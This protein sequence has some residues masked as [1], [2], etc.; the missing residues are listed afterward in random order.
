MTHRGSKRWGPWRNSSGIL[1][2][3]RSELGLLQKWLDPSRGPEE[4]EKPTS[5]VG[6][7]K[8]SCQ[9]RAPGR[10]FRGDETEELCGVDKGPTPKLQKQLGVQNCLVGKKRPCAN[11]RGG[12]VEGPKISE[13]V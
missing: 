12:G 2:G 7:E 3:A 10:G 13:N 4:D 1:G 6:R 5:F 9:T 11:R 8:R